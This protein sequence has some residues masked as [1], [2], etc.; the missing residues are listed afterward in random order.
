MREIYTYDKFG[1][2]TKHKYFILAYIKALYQSLL[3][4]VNSYVDYYNGDCIRTKRYFKGW[5][6]FKKLV[7]K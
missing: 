7:G 2:I 1:V 3:L 4:G 6:P 5:R